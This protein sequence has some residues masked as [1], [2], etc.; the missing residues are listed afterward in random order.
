M[1][2]PWF[3]ITTNKKMTMQMSFCYF[4]TYLHTCLEHNKYVLHVWQAQPSISAN[5]RDTVENSRI[6]LN[7]HT[8]NA[9]SPHACLHRNYHAALLSVD[10]IYIY[11]YMT[12]AWASGERTQTHWLNT[13]WLHLC[14]QKTGITGIFNM[15]L[16]KILI[17]D[18]IIDT[19]EK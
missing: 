11:I 8:Q 3:S 19:T 4:R 16:N 6:F 2:Q 5:G 1:D 7:T 9:A 14:F 13:H 15:I 17:L 18:T 10:L 12:W